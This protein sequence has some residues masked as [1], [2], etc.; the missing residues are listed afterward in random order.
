[1]AEFCSQWDDKYGLGNDYN[2]PE[3]ALKLKRGRSVNILCE[4]CNIR[5]IYKDDDG[6]IYLG[7]VEENEII[8]QKVSI[9]EL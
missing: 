8:L 2:L 4:G 7:R 1:M 6:F 3:I 5:T 9:E